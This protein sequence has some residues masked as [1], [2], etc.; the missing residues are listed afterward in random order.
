VAE[1][2]GGGIRTRKQSVLSGSA[3]PLAYTG[4]Y[5]YRMLEPT[6]PFPRLQTAMRSFGGALTVLVLAAAVLVLAAA[7]ARASCVPPVPTDQIARAEVI[8]FGRV[9]T[10]DR[11]AGTITFQVLTVY[12]GDPGLGRITVQ[13]GPGPRSFGG[14]TSV[15]YRADPGDHLLYL[16]KESSTFVTDDCSGSHPGQATA[17]ELGLLVV[18]GSK[19]VTH[20]PAS[21]SLD[22]FALPLLAALAAASLVTLVVVRRRSR[23]A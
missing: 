4:V 8:A 22:R 17:D 5:K 10:V 18:P 15:D 13:I 11:G 2:A 16:R 19:V 21:E 1:S 9:T 23:I 3:Q 7:P 6:E 20:E 12:K 14:A